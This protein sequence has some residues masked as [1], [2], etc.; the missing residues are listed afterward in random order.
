MCQ[1]VQVLAG[2]TWQG[3]G[4]SLQVNFFLGTP[5]IQKFTG[6]G[7]SAFVNHQAIDAYTCLLKLFMQ[8]DG[9]APV[10]ARR[11]IR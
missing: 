7:R 6:I 4:E 3:I 10:T 11:L 5:L 9:L 8:L 1:Q 2:D